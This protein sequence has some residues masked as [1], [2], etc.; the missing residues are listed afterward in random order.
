[1]YPN[2]QKPLE[3]AVDAE[4]KRGNAPAIEVS[5]SE[6]L[7]GAAHISHQPHDQTG[8]Y[9]DLQ[10]ESPPRQRGDDDQHRRVQKANHDA[11]HGVGGLGV[12]PLHRPLDHNEREDGHRDTA[13]PEQI[14]PWP[15]QQQNREHGEPASS[16]RVGEAGDISKDSGGQDSPRQR[17]GKQHVH[18]QHAG[19]GALVDFCCAKC[20]A[21]F[22]RHAMFRWQPEQLGGRLLPHRLSVRAP[23]SLLNRKWLPG[24]HLVE[25]NALIK[26]GLL[27]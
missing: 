27:G 3:H 14:H 11:N 12:Q 26:P 8:A 13:V 22:S 25:R 20:L 18:P 7:S 5:A 15:G 1:M 16:K 10:T 17:P 19:C 21:V 6:R 9:T 23:A 24:R 2:A 4:N